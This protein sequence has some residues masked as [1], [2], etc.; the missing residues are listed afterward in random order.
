MPQEIEIKLQ[1]SP[2]AMRKVRQ[3]DWLQSAPAKQAKLV[4]VYFDTPAH[5]LKDRGI[6]LRVRHAGRKR[7]QTVKTAGDGGFA[8]GE[9]ESEVRT[10]LPDL[11]A[12]GDSPLAKLAGGKLQK[13][14]KP[15]FETSVMRTAIPLR[16]GGS[17]VE[18]ALDR[19]GIKSGRRRETVSEIEIELKSGDP[20]E[21]A[22]LAERIAEAVPV[23]YEPRTKPERGYALA[24][25]AAPRAVHA[26]E[27]ALDRAMTTGEA[28][29]AIGFSCLN[30][31][32]ANEPGVRAADS[33]SVHQMRVGLRRLRAAMSVFKDLLQ[34]SESQ[35]VKAELKWLTEQ[36]G[37]ARDF[38]VFVR[39][40]VAPLT[41]TAAE[42]GVLQQDLEQR[43]DEGF[44]RAREAVDGERYRKLVLRVALWLASGIWTANADPLKR[45]PRERPVAEFASEVLSARLSK[46]V[47]KMKKL[48]K[49]DVHNRHKLRIAVKKLRYA[50]EFFDS[51][52][53]GGKRGRRKLAAV[54][55]ELQDVL[56]TL[57]DFSVHRRLAGEF[58]HDG[59]HKDRRPEKA[60]AMGIV[61]GREQ[62]RFETCMAAAMKAGGRISKRGRFWD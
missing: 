62:T 44:H 6:A 20:A 8:R 15:V 50:S 47:K 29:R 31:L 43:R 38:D 35:T 45:L 23:R 60:F 52:F 53:S 56:G 24:N 59:G 58:V 40:S 3:L 39:E 37:P 33:E 1:V 42:M 21:I 28:F 10:D 16:I 4:S 51:L 11:A 61:T 26:A 54:L 5:K 25:G 48:K 57:N 32:C 30:Q 14:L 41:H 9:W 17:E 49:L 36:L 55:E 46:I 27:V 7:I 2:A 34:D 18:I 22:R 13:K 19:G 12:A